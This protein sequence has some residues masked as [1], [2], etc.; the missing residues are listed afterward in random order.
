MHIAKSE[1]ANAGD[2]SAKDMSAKLPLDALEQT[3]DFVR[4]HIGPS[5][6]EIAEMLDAL[7]LTSLDALVDRAVPKSIRSKAPLDLPGGRTESDVLAALRGFA[8]RN[9]T[10]TSM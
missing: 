2:R 6:A 3:T 7:G 8:R 5:E 1:R 10:L 9:R 4:R